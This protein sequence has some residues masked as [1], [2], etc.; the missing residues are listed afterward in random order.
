MIWAMGAALCCVALG[1]NG[2]A[3]ARMRLKRLEDGIESLQRM[4][5]AL[6]ERQPLCSVLKSAGDGPVGRRLAETARTLARDPLMT[7]PCAWEGTGAFTETENVWWAELMERLSSGMLES[8]CQTLEQ[9]EK[10]LTWML[11]KAR[12]KEE[13]AQPLRRSLS[14]LGGLAVLLLLW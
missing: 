8:R 2:A 4:R 7:L 13:R 11:E 6:E 3:E 9:G 1:L 14:G 5:L 12:Q 10:Q